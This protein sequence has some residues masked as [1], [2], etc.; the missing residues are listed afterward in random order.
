SPP[1]AGA[2]SP[3]S[4]QAP[5]TVQFIDPAQFAEIRDHS[6][7]SDKQ[8]QAWMD[9]LRKH[10]E[11]HAAHYLPPDTHLLV[12]FTDIKLAGDYEPWRRAAMNDVRVVRD[13]YPPRIDLSYQLTSS[14][15]ATIKQGSSQLRNPAFMMQARR[16]SGDPLGYEKSML[17]DWLRTEFKTD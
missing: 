4:A 7:E 12:R 13:I 17:D 6:W 1:V 3:S 11:R 15:G 9:D 8:N 5:V 14:T 16:Y 2:A 10:L